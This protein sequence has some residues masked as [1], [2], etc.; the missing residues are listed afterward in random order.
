MT[1]DEMKELVEKVA[2]KLKGE[3]K[4]PY[5]TVERIILLL[6]FLS[7]LVTGALGLRNNSKIETVQVGQSAAV[8]VAESVQEKLDIS[9]T[10]QEK[11]LNKLER[12]TE[13]VEDSQGPILWRTWKNLE[14]DADYAKTSGLTAEAKAYGEKAA[15]AKAKFEAH[16][17]R[18][19][20]GKP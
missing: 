13:A 17:K 5:W 8:A 10:K 1:E 6:T 16:M 4:P 20:N 11:Q 9:T 19:R 2:S 7:T 3:E 14:D 15:E 12:S 18:Q